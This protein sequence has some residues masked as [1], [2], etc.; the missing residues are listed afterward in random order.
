MGKNDFVDYLVQ[1]LLSGL[2]GVKAR[3]M[4]GGHGLYLDG[5]IFGIVADDTLYFKVGDSN[6]RKYRDA[7]SRQ[8]TYTNRGKEVALPYW[9]VP[10]DVLDDREQIALW[11][12]ESSRLSR[13]S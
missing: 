9:E 1:D 4:F 12:Q 10:P 3:A 7:G 8:F 13:K 11:A 5:D 2:E 6:R